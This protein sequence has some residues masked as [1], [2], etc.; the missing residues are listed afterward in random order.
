MN[1]NNFLKVIPAIAVLCTVAL[2]A[3]CKGNNGNEPDLPKL[4][5]KQYMQSRAT[6]VAADPSDWVYFSFATGAEVQGVNEENRKERRD[7][8][9]AF[10]R[11]SIRT[12]SGLSGGGQGGA[13]LTQVKEMAEVTQAPASGYTV[14]TEI[15]LSGFANGAP[16]SKKS[17]GNQVLAEG[18]KF[19]GPPPTYTPHENVFI[20]KTADGKYAKLQFI[21]F[22]NAEG[23]SG[24]ISFKYAY[25]PNGSANLK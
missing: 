4:E 9:L 5:V 3:D 21:G 19:A 15:N 20:V 24:F 22:H 11:F 12:N 25:Q 13:L 7:W 6:S 17:T 1:K 16:V 14:D 8:D 2:F 23:K 10:N 18:I